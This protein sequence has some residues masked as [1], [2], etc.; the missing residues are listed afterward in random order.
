MYMAHPDNAGYLRYR[1]RSFIFKLGVA[2]SV[3]FIILICLN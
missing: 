1:C 2:C 3:A